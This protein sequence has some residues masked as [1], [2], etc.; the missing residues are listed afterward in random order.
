MPNTDTSQVQSAQA[1]R[2]PGTRDKG[3]ALAGGLVCLCSVL[4]AAAGAPS[5]AA[6]GRGLLQL[7]VVGVP[8]AV[9]LY[10]LRAPI[11]K[12]FGLAMLSIGFVW[13]LTALGE[14]SHSVLYTIGRISTWLT[15]PCVVYLL[16]A[17]PRGR[18][19]PGLDR[20]ILLGVLGLLVLLFL[21][22][23]PFVQAFPPKTLWSTCTT[24]CPANAIFVL[25]Q[26]PAFM[27]TV[28]LVREWL[29]ELLWLGLFYSMFRRWRVASPLQRTAMGPAFIAGTLLGLFHIAHHTSRQLGAPADTVIALSS[30]WTLCIVAVCAGFLFGLLWRRMLLAGALARLGIALRAGDDRQRMRDALAIA[31]GDPTS[32]LVFRDPSGAWHDARSPVTGRRVADALSLIHDKARRRSWTTRSCWT[33]S[34]G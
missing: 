34:A 24:D 2:A 1:T 3:L 7:L 11:N 22:T 18:V 6:F 31:L 21:G 4:M 25:E 23:A 12:S 29:V 8:I 13:S 5:D 28:V 30:V 26:Q 15:F 16:L 32:Q 19:E 9:G 10:A 20:A 33:V 14:S 17:F 27:S